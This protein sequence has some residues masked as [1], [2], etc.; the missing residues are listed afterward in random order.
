MEA[1]LGAVGRDGLSAGSKTCDHTHNAAFS[2]FEKGQQWQLAL[3]LLAE[4]AFVKVDKT[5]ITY[6][7]AISACEK[8]H[9]WELALGVL[10]EMAFVKAEMDVITHS[11]AISACEKGHQ[12]QLAVG[13]LAEMAFVKAAVD[14]GQDSR[15]STSFQKVGR[16]HLPCGG[17]W[18]DCAGLIEG[19][20]TS[21]LIAKRTL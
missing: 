2:A 12:W 19:L 8:G 9:E 15:P 16:A 10:A 18:V 21:P 11:A 1:G 6:N 13:L 5:A 7:A 4:M 17:C 20:C 14:H 3:G